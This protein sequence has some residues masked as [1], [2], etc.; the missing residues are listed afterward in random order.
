M[1]AFYYFK[2]ILKTKPPE[3]Y[4]ATVQFYYG[5]DV[6][7]PEAV[8]KAAV[9]RFAIVFCHQIQVIYRFVDKG[10][11]GTERIGSWHR[12]RDRL[13]DNPSACYKH[14]PDASPTLPPPSWKDAW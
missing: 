13:T 12:W 11:R 14:M 1:S 3:K 6:V 9:Y 5:V 4:F 7:F 8:L 10:S 2:W